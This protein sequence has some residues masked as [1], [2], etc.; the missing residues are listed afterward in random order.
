MIQLD[1]S[2]LIR[3]LAAGSAEDTSLR[4]WL[5]AR[6]P[7]AISAVA[8]AEFRCGPVSDEVASIANEIVGTPI[9]F[10]AE[11]AEIAASLFHAGGRRRGTL[12]DCLIA[13]C[14]IA[15]DASLATSNALDFQRF[16]VH[17]LRLATTA[18]R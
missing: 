18:G 10:T 5:R 11:H 8:W 16:V 3:A 13:A 4:A 2:F 6:M 15:G 1:T 17:G 12:M 9:V 7:L 14:A